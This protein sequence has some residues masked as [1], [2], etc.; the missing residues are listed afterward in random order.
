MSNFHAKRQAEHGAWAFIGAF[1]VVIRLYS[2]IDL[3]IAQPFAFAIWYWMWFLTSIPAYVQIS[4][5]N[6][7]RIAILRCAVRVAGYAGSGKSTL[8]PTAVC[9]ARGAVFA[10]RPFR[11]TIS[12]CSSIQDEERSSQEAHCTFFC[13][14][15]RRCIRADLTS[16]HRHCGD[17]ALL[18]MDMPTVM[19]HAC[20]TSCCKRLA[21]DHIPP[22]SCVR[23]TVQLPG[24]TT[25]YLRPAHSSLYHVPESACR[26]SR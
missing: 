21:L 13:L 20:P 9:V 10:F 24:S 22:V 19:A 16:V 23:C 15:M 2:N 26:C 12:I 14:N 18:H 7:D 11:A 3:V 6:V 5:E 8:L 17:Y 1:S 25:G 4:N